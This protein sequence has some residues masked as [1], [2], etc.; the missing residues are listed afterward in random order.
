MF[1]YHGNPD[2][3]KRV[4]FFLSNVIW[5]GITIKYHDHAE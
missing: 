4:F 1:R 3:D 2:V 5:H